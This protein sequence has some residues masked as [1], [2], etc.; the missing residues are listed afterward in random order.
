MSKKAVSDFDFHSIKNGDLKA[1]RR[2]FEELYPELVNYAYKI[3]RIEATA[4]E[5]VQEVF[6]YIWEKREVSSISSTLKGYVYS[7]VKNR[8]INF[9]KL[10]LPKAQA[11]ADIEDTDLSVEM[12]SL[13]HHNTELLEALIDEA[14]QQ[15]PPKC[16]NIFLLSRAAGLTY[17][18]IADELEIS[19]KTVENQ[20]SIALK[21]LRKALDPVVKRINEN[22]G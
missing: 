20:M 17:E 2:F 15:L 4:E 6:I 3:I 9:I 22:K 12:E 8:C 21:K 1:F 11:T 16:K 10:E 14:V 5:I 7:A 19:I 13:D 18:E